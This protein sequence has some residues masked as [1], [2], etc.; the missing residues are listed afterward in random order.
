MILSEEQSAAVNFESNAVV[1]ACP[2]SGKTR[3]LTAR[4][5][6][7][8]ESNSP[9]KEKIAALTY[10]NRAA[11]EINSRLSRDG[12]PTCKLWAGTIHA[13]ALEWVLRPYAPYHNDLR[14]GFRVADEYYCEKLIT[15]IKGELKIA[16]FDNINTSYTRNG[17]VD[18]NCAKTR[19][20]YSE[21]R[22][23]LRK[24]KLIDFDEV[25]YFSYKLLEDNPEIAKNLSALFSLF[26]VDEVQDIQDLQY[27]ILSKIYKVE[28]VAPVMFFVGDSDQSIYETLGA[29]TLS[30]DEIAEEFE[31]DSIKHFELTGNYRSTQRIIDF[32]G[33][34]RPY[35]LHCESLTQDPSRSGTVA[36]SDQEIHKDNLAD[37]IAFLVNEAL[38]SGVPENDICV[39]APQWMHVRS[40]ARQLVT[41]L[42][43]VSFDAP[44]LS[45]LY[46]LRE[47]I[48]YKFA[49]LFLTRPHPSQIRSRLLCAND[50]LRELPLE[51]GS[52]L[53]TALLTSRKLLRLVNSLKSSE[54][55]GLDY[56]YQQFSQL[57]AAC[58][59]VLEDHPIL[60]ESF[61]LF[62]E[63]AS[64]NIEVTEKI[65]KGVNSFKKIFSPSGVVM[66]TCHGVKGE[67]FDTVIAFGLLRGYIPHWD[68]I[69]NGSGNQACENEWKLLYVIAS[70]AKTNLHLI[71]EKG[72]QTQS[73]SPYSTSDLL[74]RV[75]FDYDS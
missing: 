20:G 22:E 17:K 51:L 26:C 3:V 55:N 74:Y 32:C 63:K 13:F 42:P 23:H 1:T 48:W 34:L 44:G 10:T 70:R 53:P 36:F 66:N 33:T 73:G 57:L 7:E 35:Q 50:V 5:I 8:L 64:R 59:L 67:E 52:E 24:E 71:A 60:E 43:D 9:S 31:M 68:L 12:I 6:K 27:A 11:D 30:P 65:L 41:N 47:N 19:Q 58:Q 15:S 62:F 25:L 69:I 45:P 39:I 29:L 49:K 21:Y 14:K 4:V 61:N 40:M 56:L 46:N 54:R 16:R 37:H 2:G 38:E 18:N 75:E 28:Q 72:R